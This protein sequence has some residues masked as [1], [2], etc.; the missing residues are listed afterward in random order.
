MPN[1]SLNVPHFKQELPYSC[2]AAC[3]RMVLAHHGQQRTE[4]ELRQLLNTRPHGTPARNLTAVGP[5]GFDVKLG[6]GNLSQLRDALVAGQ[7]PVVFLDMGPL[8]YWQI[9]CSHVAVVVGID[10]TS[11][12]LNDPFFD[13]APQQTSLSSFLQAWALNGHLAVVFRPRP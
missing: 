5:L 1:A 2:V 4:A 8:D 7:A 10:D 9:D 13:S 12:Y 11:V 6:F 3:V